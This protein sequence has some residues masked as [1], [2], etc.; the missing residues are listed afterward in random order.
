MQKGNQENASDQILFRYKYI[1]RSMMMT[2]HV[3]LLLWLR[4]RAAVPT[5]PKTLGRR[6][7]WLSIWTNYLN[8]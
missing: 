4:I 7:V 6:R 8:V 3:H 5:L 1:G 2:A